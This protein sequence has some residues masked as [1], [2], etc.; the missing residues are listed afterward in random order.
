MFPPENSEVKN[1]PLFQREIESLFLWFDRE[2]REA[3][4]HRIF[5]M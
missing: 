2:A 4:L 3:D 5:I 1:P